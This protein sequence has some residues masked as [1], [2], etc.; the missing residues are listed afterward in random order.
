MNPHHKFPYYTS[1]GA[2]IDMIN[3][4]GIDSFDVCYVSERSNGDAVEFES[5]FQ[6]AL[7][8]AE[9]DDWINQHNT[10]S[11]FRAPLKHTEESKKKMSKSKTGRKASPET[12]KKMSESAKN[13]TPEMK[14]RISE[15]LIGRPV[16]DETKAKMSKAKLGKRLSDE[17]KAKISKTKLG[18]PRTEKQ[19]E[20][21]KIIQSSEEYK[22]KMSKSKTGQLHSDETR[23]KISLSQ[24]NRKIEIKTC[25]HCHKC[26]RAS[27]MTRYHFK[28]CKLFTSVSDI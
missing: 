7:N 6:R 20:I 25:P 1:S 19:N 2:I 17:T 21:L 8:V 18:K 27:N 16:S 13:K 3:Q 11:K 22:T 14:R 24:K 28:N 5:M 26:G 12:K 4:H 9:S 23:A 10:G 15:S